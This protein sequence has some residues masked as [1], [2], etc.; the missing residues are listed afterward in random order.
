[1]LG[2]ILENV[3]GQSM[4]AAA[5]KLIDFDRLGLADTWWEVLEPKPGGMLPRAHQYNYV[6]GWDSYGNDPPFD[7]FGGGIVSTTMDLARFFYALFNGH[8][9]RK[10]ETIKVMES[11]VKTASPRDPNA[12]Y[13]FGHGLQIQ[14]VGDFT[15]YGHG[16][17]WGV[18]AGYAPALDMSVS[19]IG[20]RKESLERYRFGAWEVMSEAERL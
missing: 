15:V 14:E 11:V 4:A 5:R 20:L 19:V 12:C 10:A 13:I 7:L 8:V 2:A 16:G 17:L 9:F 18:Y 6:Q 3:T 1:M